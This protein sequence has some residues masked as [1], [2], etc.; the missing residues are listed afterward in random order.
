MTHTDL[1]DFS[2]TMQQKFRMKRSTQRKIRNHVLH[3]Y[4]TLYGNSAGWITDGVRSYF[5]QLFEP[6]MTLTK[7]ATYIL[8][9]VF[10]SGGVYAS[11]APESFTETMTHVAVSMKQAVW[12]DTPVLD[13]QTNH[14]TDIDTAS[15]VDTTDAQEVG[16]GTGSWEILVT[17][18]LSIAEMAQEDTK[19][20]TQKKVSDNVVETSVEAVAVVDAHIAAEPVPEMWWIQAETDVVIETEVKVEQ[21]LHDVIDERIE[22]GV[23]T[24]QALTALLGEHQQTDSDVDDSGVTDIFIKSGSMGSV[25]IGNKTVGVV[26]SALTLWDDDEIL[27]AEIEASM[28]VSQDAGDVAKE[29]VSAGVEESTQTVKEVDDT[30]DETVEN[31]LDTTDGLEVNAEV[32]QTTKWLLGL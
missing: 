27:G 14:K 23:S 2:R 13:Y 15:S 20:Y 8:W 6:P 3:Y 30:L 16:S 18:S 11:V 17:E 25:W 12:I 26:Q 29:V 4:H 9:V 22:A 19:N 24:S 31:V 1:P 10:L 5:I 28:S 32:K 7:I 21:K